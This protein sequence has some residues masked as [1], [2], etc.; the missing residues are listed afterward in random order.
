MTRGPAVAVLAVLLLA[1]CTRVTAGHGSVTVS[2]FPTA[3]SHTSVERYI[4]GSAALGN[5]KAVRCNGGR[6]FPLHA[7]GDTFTCSDDTDRSFLVTI[8]NPQDGSYVVS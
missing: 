3:L 5:P 1:G 6:D 2:P 4:E 7:A 8:T